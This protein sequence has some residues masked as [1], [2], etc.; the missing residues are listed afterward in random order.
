MKTTLPFHLIIKP[1]GDECNLRCSY[2]FYC[3]KT[4]A[5]GHMSDTVLEDVVQK[6][7]QEQP[8]ACKEVQF[9]WQG[10]EPLLAGLAF[11]RKA[12]SL[13]EKYK[14]EGT[15]I[16]NAIQTNG[17]LLDNEWAQF[18]A[19]NDFLIG[20]SIDG[21]Q[22]LHDSCRINGAN[23]GS[24]A[25]VM[26]GL[27][28]L[29]EQR[30][31]FNALTVVHSQNVQAAESIYDFL[32]AE[33]V[34]S[35]QFLPAIAPSSAD[36]NQNDPLCIQADEWGNFL[37]AIFDRWLKNGLDKISVQLFEA[38]FRRIALGV[39]S[40]CVHSSVCGRNLAVEANGDVYSCD[41]YV[42]PAHMLGNISNHSLQDLL[43]SDIQKQFICSSVSHEANCSGCSIKG[44]CQGGCP[45]YRNSSGRN[46]LCAGYKRFFIYS[47]PYFWAMNECIRRKQHINLYP[48][49]LQQ[50]KRAFKN[51]LT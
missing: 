46:Y 20:L 14:R 19:D 21:P 11:Y 27:K 24:F 25:K 49:Y 34:D 12:I 26:A 48:L 50:S 29:K 10:G 6:Y 45:R 33:G 2:C 44:L 22:H 7:I 5:K 32:A 4:E 1:V 18:F 51:Q 23:R 41:H 17:V 9:V 28:L 8:E 37:I 3:G 35:M 42:D 16:T 30:V 38:T 40:F 47:A 39:E 13:Q 43:A 15:L 31:N 36:G